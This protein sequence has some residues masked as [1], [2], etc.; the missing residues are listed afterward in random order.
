M[1][2][3]NGAQWHTGE[4]KIEDFKWH[5]IGVDG[6]T[7]TG[8]A[9]K[10]MAQEMTI[11]KMGQRNLPP[12][13]I[14]MSD[15]EATDD[16]EGGIKSLLS[17]PWGKKS[18]RIAIAVGSDANVAELS[19]FCSNPKENPPLVADRASDLIRFIK[20]ASTAVVQ[21]VSNSVINNASAPDANVNVHIPPPP[22]QQQVAIGGND[23]D[24][25]DAI[26]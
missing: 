20:W 2:F 3:S 25:E 17:T 26:F 19:K 11:E 1:K 15:G 21:S 8:A 10:L 4:T 24:W 9:L 16:Y 13:I 12:V 7:E 6:W 5:D 23:Q 18:V 14:L 22:P